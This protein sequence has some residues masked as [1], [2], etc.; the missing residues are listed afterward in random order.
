MSQ[1][2]PPRTDDGQLHLIGSSIKTA[3]TEFEAT[4]EAAT[5]EA[6]ETGPA[7]RSLQAILEQIRTARPRTT[8]LA[9]SWGNIPW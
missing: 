9:Q 3:A 7:D 6:K 1:V 2:R 5:R 4:F 8:E